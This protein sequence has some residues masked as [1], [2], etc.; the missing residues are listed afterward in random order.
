M[1]IYLL[2]RRALAHTHTRNFFARIFMIARFQTKAVLMG[3][4]EE[5]R[6]SQC[7]QHCLC[8]RH[9]NLRKRRARELRYAYHTTTDHPSVH[10]FIQS[11]LVPHSHTHAPI[12]MYIGIELE[13][14]LIRTRE[15][16][17]MS[18]CACSLAEH[19]SVS[20]CECECECVAAH[21]VAWR[22]FRHYKCAI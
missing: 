20:E 4:K 16:D 3:Y 15:C 5:I 11:V 8:L 12:P 7:V 13:R 9:F 2:K 19:V 18:I 22:N 6:S 14:R 10:P 21:R 17:G 1:R